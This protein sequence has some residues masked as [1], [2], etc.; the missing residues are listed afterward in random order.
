MTIEIA[1]FWMGVLVLLAGVIGGAIRIGYVVASLIADTKREF[2]ALLTLK[3]AEFD[4]KVGRV[5]ERFDGY[6]STCDTTFMRKDM[7]AQIHDSSTKSF[8]EIA[9]RMESMEKKIDALMVHQIENQK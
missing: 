6:K 3:E 2:N 4:S 5:Y 9:R 8:N 7:C 1:Q